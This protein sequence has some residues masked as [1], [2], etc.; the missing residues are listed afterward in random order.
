M[1]KTRPRGPIVRGSDQ[2]ILQSGKR[3][4]MENCRKVIY[5]GPERIILLGSIRLAVTGKALRLMELGNDNVEIRGV[6]RTVTL[7]EEQ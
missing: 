1:A 3:L 4:V 2:V 7:G 5:C 6:I